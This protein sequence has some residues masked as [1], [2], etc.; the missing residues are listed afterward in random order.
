VPSS[1]SSDLRVVAASGI[2][3]G[4]VSSARVRLGEPVAGVVAETGRPLLVNGGNTFA[5][6]IGQRVSQYSSTS[7]ISAPV[8]LEEGGYGV[9]NVADPIGRERFQ[10]EDLDAVEALAR[11]IGREIVTE[12]LRARLA[13]AEESVADL[14]RELIWVQESERNRLARD[15]HDEAG[16]ALTLAIFQIDLQ[17]V[18][19]DLPPDVKE[20]LVQ[21]RDV[22]LN[23]ATALNDMAFRLRPRILD[24]LGLV[25]ALRTLIAQG[26]EGLRVELQ[27]SGEERSLRS[28]V[29]L[30]AFRVAQEALT[31]VRKHARAGRAW[32]HLAFEPDMLRLLVQ[33]NGIG[34][35]RRDALVGEHRSQ[36]LRGMQE[37]VGALGG[38]LAVGPRPARG[39]CLEVR[40][41]LRSREVQHD[42]Q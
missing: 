7:F 39:T 22:M 12:R 5:E 1:T 38:T 29:E 16:H 13:R 24:D 10:N 3:L 42:D 37:R 41:P 18:R 9:L 30:V 25:P 14:R 32:V 20:S 23:C 34:M 15:L 33:D 27:I 2:P 26:A 17:R 6:M 11:L 4:T 28:E 8:P 36:G 21:A 19:G 40:L 35:D 31:N